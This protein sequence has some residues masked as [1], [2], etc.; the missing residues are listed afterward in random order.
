MTIW[1]KRTD[2]G[3]AQCR[4]CK[5]PPLPAGWDRDSDCGGCWAYNCGKPECMTGICDIYDVS[6]EDFEVY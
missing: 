5:V 6:H 4:V 1:C 3:K 2:S